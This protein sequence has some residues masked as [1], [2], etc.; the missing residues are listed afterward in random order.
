MLHIEK[1][2]SDNY[3][4]TFCVEGL[5]VKEINEILDASDNGLDRRDVLVKVMNQHD[6]DS[7]YGKNIAEGWRNGYGIYGIRH[8]GGHLFVQVGNSC[9]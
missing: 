9:D 2:Y 1:S 8:V 6:N 7:R 4:D 3:F 5:S